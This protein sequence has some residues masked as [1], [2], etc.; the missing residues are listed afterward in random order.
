[1]NLLN[2]EILNSKLLLKNSSIVLRLNASKKTFNR[3]RFC[4][5]SKF[6]IHEAYL[7]KKLFIFLDWLSS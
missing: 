5:K 1:M 2:S 6:L 4:Y 7:D 3:F